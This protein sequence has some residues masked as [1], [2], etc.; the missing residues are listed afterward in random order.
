MAVSHGTEG[1]RP[2]ARCAN[3]TDVLARPA[4]VNGCFVETE[5]TAPVSPMLRLDSVD[6]RF[7]V[8]Q[9]LNGVSLQLRHREVLAL[10]GASGCGKTTLLRIISGLSPFD[11]GRLAIEDEI[12]VPGAPYPEGLY[13]R[14]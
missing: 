8:R 14:I 9:L 2:E 3:G 5:S 10:C 1:H 13:G 7:G 11:D 6:K 4:A 12:I